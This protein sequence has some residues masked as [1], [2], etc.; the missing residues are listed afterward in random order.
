MR[1]AAN[2]NAHRQ[3]VAAGDRRL[4]FSPKHGSAA[5]A[6]PT[7]F[8][9]WASVL[10]TGS[11]FWRTT[12][13]SPPISFWGA[14]IAN[15]MRGPLYPRNARESHLHMLAHTVVAEKYAAEI[16]A[17]RDELPDLAHV[18]VR[19]QGC[20]TWL[21]R[22][23]AVDPDPPIDPEDYFII[24]HTGGT[25]GKSKG[26]A[27]THHAWLA[28]G[29][30]WFYLDPPV[31]PGLPAA[32]NVMAEKF[33][34]ATL[35]GLMIK[36]RTAH[37]FMLPTILNAMNRIPGIEQRRFPHLKCMLVSAASIS[38]ETA[39]KAYEIFGDAMYQGY[40]RT[41]VLPVAMMGRGSGLPRMC[42][43]PSRCL[44]HAVALR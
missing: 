6:W 11:A 27:Y 9:H 23:S 28:A 20:E 12:R 32:R 37:R 38:D 25:A 24:R 44:R 5:Y 34:P 16:E 7:D 30:D 31:E 10:R 21:A 1:S 36:E 22:Q 33:D 42:L 41:E 8:L 26:V 3:P 13:S 40:G 19:D 18:L 39:L 17:I 4:T 15:L 2:D 29:R 35:P 14:A 43:A